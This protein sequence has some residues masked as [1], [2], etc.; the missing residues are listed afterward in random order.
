MEQDHTCAL[1]PRDEDIHMDDAV[2]SL[3]LLENLRIEIG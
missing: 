1:V 2:I 3:Q